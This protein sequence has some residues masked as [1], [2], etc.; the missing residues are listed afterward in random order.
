MNDS[1]LPLRGVLSD[2]LWVAVREGQPVVLTRHGRPAAVVVDLA[3]WGE[4]EALLDAGD[5]AEGEMAAR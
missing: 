1:V 2:R 3:S 5:G 4:V